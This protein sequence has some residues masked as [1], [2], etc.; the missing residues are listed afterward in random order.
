MTQVQFLAKL[1]FAQFV[2]SFKVAGVEK[3]GGLESDKEI[4][5]EKKNKKTPKHWRDGGGTRGFLSLT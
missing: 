2:C 5:G 3:G 4:R 1:R